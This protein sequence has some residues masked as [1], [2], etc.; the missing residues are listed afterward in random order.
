MNI[1][2]EAAFNTVMQFLHS[3]EKQN[4]EECLSALSR[5]Q[6]LLLL[7]TNVGE[8]FCSAEEIRAAF[9]KDFSCMSNIRW[10]E[11]RHVH[12][13]ACEKLASVIMELSVSYQLEG[14]NE[15]TEIGRAH[16]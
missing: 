1:E 13:V 12:V 15:E 9:T 6:P 16:V 2:E 10:G 3:Y 14:K 5:S 8:L 4:I 11:P 7:G